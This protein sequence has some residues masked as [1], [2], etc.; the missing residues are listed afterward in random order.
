MV[1]FNFK[2][3]QY[4]LRVHVFFDCTIPDV[5]NK[6]ST[7]KKPVLLTDLRDDPEDLKSAE[8]LAHMYKDGSFFIWSKKKLNSA[9]DIGTLSH[10]IFHTVYNMRIY[11]GSPI[12]TPETEE[13]WAYMISW[14]TEQIFKKYEIYSARG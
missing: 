14:L 1:Y 13:D 11:I 10:E 3:S 8:G 2:H 6:I 12:L 4:P 7:K 5:L 9:V